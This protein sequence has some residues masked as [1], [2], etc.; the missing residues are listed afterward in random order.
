MPT[1]TW[2][3]KR[4]RQ[5]RLDDG[6]RLHVF[7]GR[8]IQ[9]AG[10]TQRLGPHG[11]GILVRSGDPTGHVVGQGKGLIPPCR[12]RYADRDQIPAG[13]PGIIESVRN[14]QAIR[15]LIVDRLDQLAD[16][17][18]VG[19][20][21]H[22]AGLVEQVEA[23][24]AVRYALVSPGE[25]GPVHGADRLHV[26]VR[27]Q[28][29][30]LGR[31]GHRV[32][33]RPVEVEADVY[34]VAASILDGLIDPL[35][36]RLIELHPV[37]VLDPDA[38]VHRQPHEI[39]TQLRDKLEIL[40]F[41]RPRGTALI[42]HLQQ[43]EPAPPRQ[44]PCR[45]LRLCQGRALDHSPEQQRDPESL[46]QCLLLHDFAV[47]VVPRSGR[48]ILHPLILPIPGAEHPPSRFP[49]LRPVWSGSG[50]PSIRQRT[51]HLGST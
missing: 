14:N 29:V 51:G 6:G 39:E 43:I 28:A 18:G 15:V 30:R 46:H 22:A 24:T 47:P 21:V 27:P 11:H 19:I 33:R 50:P 26:G 5:V 31:V 45:R 2:S 44:L 4:L 41:E 38:V 48:P 40:L 23:Q 36:G 42:E 1:R 3:V 32:P 37:P 8:P 16:H 34:A 10:T 9:I 35:Q 13:R 7:L 17:L 20:G 25:G 12:L 49:G